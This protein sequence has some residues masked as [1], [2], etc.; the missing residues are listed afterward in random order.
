MIVRKGNS[1][2]LSLPLSGLDRR[3]WIDSRPFQWI[4]RV[5]GV[6]RLLEINRLLGIVL[7][8]FNQS[9]LEEA[10]TG[11]GVLWHA[12]TN[13]AKYW[14]RCDTFKRNRLEEFNAKSEKD[15]WIAGASGAL[16]FQSSH[17]GGQ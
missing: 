9:M 2:T 7:I 1:C 10:L 8:D 14:Q 15:G 12:G 3:F 17:G 5:F 13:P 4:A 16:P 11:H 6:F